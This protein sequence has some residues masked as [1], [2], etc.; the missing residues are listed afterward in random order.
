VNSLK[1][2]DVLCERDGVTP[3]F[4][5][6]LTIVGVLAYVALTGYAIVRG[7]TI[8]YSEWAVGFTTILVGGAGGARL[9]LQTENGEPDEDVGDNHS[10]ADR[11]WRSQ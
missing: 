2:R 9:K 7:Q 8:G 11:D 4:V 3:C 10:G 5:R 1:W 6:V